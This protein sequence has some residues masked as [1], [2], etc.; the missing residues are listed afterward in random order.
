MSSCRSCVSFLAA[1]RQTADVSRSGKDHNLRLSVLKIN[2]KLRMNKAP[3]QTKQTGSDM[4]SKYTESE[5]PFP[6]LGLAQEKSRT[7][8]KQ[9]MIR[10]NPSPGEIGMSE[11]R[12]FLSQE[13][14]L[15]GRHSK[16]GPGKD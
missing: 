9:N 8:H 10:Q 15:E 16:R 14:E 7:G 6:A 11:A 3:S 12:A 5:M 1:G 4:E 2:R 13:D